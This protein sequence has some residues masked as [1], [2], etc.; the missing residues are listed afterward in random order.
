[1]TSQPSRRR[2]PPGIRSQ[3]FSL[4]ASGGAF[5]AVFLAS[6]SPPPRVDPAKDG[7]FVGGL[8]GSAHD[9][10][11]GEGGPR[12]LCLPCHAPHL[13]VSPPPKW[14]TRPS[15]RGPLAT[16]DSRSIELDR[17]SLLC[18]SCHDGVV[19]HDV[20]T[21][22]HSVRL[23]AEIGREGVGFGGLQGHPVGIRYPVGRKDYHSAVE[24]TGRGLALP[25]ERI[26]CTTCHDPHNTAR[27]PGMLVI[28][29]ERSRLC[30]T[31][32]RI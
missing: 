13:P 19:A 4:L 15:A 2:L 27:H 9:F 10:T 24:V 31:C 7:Q 6:A 32:H 18:M 11:R 17:G 12:D 30:L 20:F 28:S 21:S 14:D 1:M 25:D 22:A 29:N 5:L 16:Y 23:S 8:V 26:Q 3:W